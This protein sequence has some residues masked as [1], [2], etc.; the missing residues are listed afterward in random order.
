MGFKDTSGDTAQYQANQYKLATSMI[1]NP[2]KPDVAG[3]QKDARDQM[4]QNALFSKDLEQRINPG[5]SATR[6]NLQKQISDDLSSNGQLDTAAQ[7]SVIRSGL[8]QSLAAGTG[9]Q[10]ANS[11]GNKSIVNNLLNSTYQRRN[12]NQEKASQL[13]GNNQVGPGGLDASSLA[14]LS[15]SAAQSAYENP[16]NLQ[17]NAYNTTAAL[18]SQNTNAYNQNLAGVY[19]AGLNML[20]N[21]GPKSV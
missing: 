21:A 7:N 13:L 6:E 1:E 18:Q 2:Y 17:N 3:M 4:Y 14:A 5:V 10:G 16:Y 9:T 12:Q 15:A 11:T 8:G 20:G 19:S